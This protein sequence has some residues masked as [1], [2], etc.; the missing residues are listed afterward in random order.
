MIGNNACGSRAL[1]YGRTV[2][3]RRRRST[4]SPA[5]A[6]RLDAAGRAHRAAATGSTPW[7]TTTSATIRTEFGRFTRQVSRLLASST[8]CPRTAATST[9]SWSAREGTL[10]GGRSGRP[11]GWSRTRP[12]RPLVVLG[13]PSMVEAAD[14]VPGAAATT[15][16][17]ACEGLDARI[18][19]VVRARRGAV[20]DLP[21][22]AGW[23]FV[24]VTGDDRPRRPRGRGRGGRAT[25]ARST[26]GW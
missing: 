11:S 1:G 13:Y 5:T 6:A 10:G 16:L 7:S 25:P 22:G 15:R 24:E 8:C 20:P 17:V 21:R 12:R 14:A 3:Q 4:C 23:L 26:H 19:D 9:G 2:R 18:V